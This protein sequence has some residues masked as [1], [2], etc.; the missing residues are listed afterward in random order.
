MMRQGLLLLNLGDGESLTGCLSGTDS[1]IEHFFPIDMNH[2][3]SSSG[4]MSLIVAES[5]IAILDIIFI[6]DTCGDDVSG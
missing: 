6:L 1:T 3:L 2:I 5:L 4:L